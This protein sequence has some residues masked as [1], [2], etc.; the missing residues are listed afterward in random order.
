MFN[1]IDIVSL[2]A[3]EK[4]IEAFATPIATTS[5]KNIAD[6][7][8][9]LL[10]NVLDFKPQVEAITTLAGQVLFTEN[11]SY[12]TVNADTKVTKTFNPFKE[13]RADGDVFCIEQP[14]LHYSADHLNNMWRTNDFEYT[15]VT[16]STLFSLVADFLTMYLN[17]DQVWVHNHRK[18]RENALQ[19][20][21]NLEKLVYTWLPDL[22]PD[23]QKLQTEIGSEQTSFR[24]LLDDGSRTRAEILKLYEMR[25]ARYENVRLQDFFDLQPVRVVVNELYIGLAR[26]I[27]QLFP[28]V[29]VLAERTA[30]P[31]HGYDVYRAVV[32]GQ[33]VA[34]SS[35][36]DY[37]V[38]NWELNK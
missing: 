9:H 33:R 13:T 24:L 14:N 12:Y 10:E 32:V 4:G 11:L 36:G 38:L 29:R 28:T 27:T 35:L 7:I 3:R 34:V 23:L 25:G 21:L 31:A 1:Y 16:N 30:H 5:L 17:E 37:R 22:V 2:L 20:Y 6:A 8:S 19:Q 26:I 15:Y 18:P